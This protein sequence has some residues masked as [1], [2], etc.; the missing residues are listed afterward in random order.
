MRIQQVK[1]ARFV[2]STVPIIY[3]FYK[4][5]TENKPVVKI[6]SANIEATMLARP[7]PA[8]SS[9]ITALSN[10]CCWYMTKSHKYKQPAHTCQMPQKRNYIW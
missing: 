3:L 9:K 5:F 2:F 1:L 6:L 7:T 4:H 10:S 8:P